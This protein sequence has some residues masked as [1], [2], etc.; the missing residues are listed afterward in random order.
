MQRPGKLGNG[1]LPNAPYLAATDRIPENAFTASEN[2]V[3]LFFLEAKNLL[4]Q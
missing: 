1:L 3:H 4:Q 2:R